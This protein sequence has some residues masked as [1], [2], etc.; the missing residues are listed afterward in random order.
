M[1]LKLLAAAE[2]PEQVILAVLLEYRAAAAAALEAT[3]CSL[4]A[5]EPPGRGI[6]AEAFLRT[7]LALVA[8]ALAVLDKILLD[9]RLLV[10]AESAYLVL[11]AARHCF[12]PVAAVGLAPLAAMAAAALAA[13]EQMTPLLRHLA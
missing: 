12:T 8:V 3:A 13:M 6:M 9:L 11:S 5:Q 7:H 10:T 2:G 4:A 1:A